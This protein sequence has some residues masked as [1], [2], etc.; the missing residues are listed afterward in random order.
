MDCAN[1]NVA[2][3]SVV[4]S[5]SYIQTDLSGLRAAE[6]KHLSPADRIETTGFRCARTK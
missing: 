6:R 4:R 2:K 3:S 1:L 5:S